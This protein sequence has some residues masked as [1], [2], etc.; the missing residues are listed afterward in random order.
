MLQGL[1]GKKVQGKEEREQ[2]GPGRSGSR[3]AALALLGPGWLV[4]RRGYYS[5]PSKRAYLKTR[6]L[7]GSSLEIMG[8]HR[9]FRGQP[10]PSMK[11]SFL[12]PE[13]RVWGC[14]ARRPTSRRPD[15][16]APFLGGLQAH[17]ASHFIG[18]TS[19]LSLVPEAAQ[20]VGRGSTRA[21]G[22]RWLILDAGHLGTFFVHFTP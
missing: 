8:W 20:G 15:P 1:V 14:M 5:S 6:S 3:G 17:Y 9:D 11:P 13:F 12:W 7:S 19:E 18:E 4:G 22:D 16:T 21:R 10:A 2:V